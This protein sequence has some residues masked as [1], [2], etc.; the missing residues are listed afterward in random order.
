VSLVTWGE[1]LDVH[2]RPAPA[3]AV[4]VT[5]GSSL[6]FGLVDWGK[7]RENVGKLFHRVAGF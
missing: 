2:L 7:N 6:K 5:I 4:E 1:D 3:G